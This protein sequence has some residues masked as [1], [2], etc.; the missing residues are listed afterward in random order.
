MSD[1][2]D[3]NSNYLKSPDLLPVTHENRSIGMMG[4]GV[5]WVG[6]AIVLAAFAIGAGG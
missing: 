6:M 4:F 2:K 3:T 1:R 5:I